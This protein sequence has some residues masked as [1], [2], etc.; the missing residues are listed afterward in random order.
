MV[1]SGIRKTYH[2]LTLRMDHESYE[3]LL[4]FLKYIDYDKVEAVY[5]MRTSTPEQYA[6]PL[7]PVLS[8]IKTA[9]MVGSFETPD[10]D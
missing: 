1:T 4:D 7:M 6:K 3:V 2:E 9:M 5:D 10:E 8:A